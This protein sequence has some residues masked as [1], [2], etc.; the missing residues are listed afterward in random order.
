MGFP[1]GSWYSS[2]MDR[3]GRVSDDEQLVQFEA[4]DGRT[5]TSREA[6]QDATVKF[7]MAHSRDNLSDAEKMFETL[8][9]E[10]LR[11]IIEKQMMSAEDAAQVEV[12]RQNA[13]DF[14]R[15]HP[16]YIDD[17]HSKFATVRAKAEFNGVIMR[18][19]LDVRGWKNPTLEQLDIVYNSLRSKGLLNLDSSKLTAELAEEADARVA[20]YKAKHH[21]VTDAEWE[22]MTTAEREELRN[23]EIRSFFGQR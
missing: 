16:E 4:E 9:A 21:D 3:F 6:A 15:L 17:V 10:Q 11:S 2:Q 7:R 19:E 5:Y 20:E 8:S 12:T 18:H 14:I 23:S 1:G 13:D 22:S